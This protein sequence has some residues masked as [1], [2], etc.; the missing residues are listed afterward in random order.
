MGHICITRGFD[1]ESVL[2]AAARM[3][4]KRRTEARDARSRVSANARV[5]NAVRSFEQEL[6]RKCLRSGITLRN[7]IGLKTALP[8]RSI[9]RVK[10]A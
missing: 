2:L 1:V 3:E 10:L 9:E 7:W 4:D 8:F 5:R 6:V